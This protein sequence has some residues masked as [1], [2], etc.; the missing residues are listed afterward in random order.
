MKYIT[1]L[2]CLFLITNVSFAQ[3]IFFYDD[4]FTRDLLEHGGIKY[5]YQCGKGKI[6]KI[7]YSL[8]NSGYK[9]HDVVILHFDKEGNLIKRKA[10]TIYHNKKEKKQIP[11]IKNLCFPKDLNYQY[12]YQYNQDKQVSQIDSPW[13]MDINE[14]FHRRK[15]RIVYDKNGNVLQKIQ[16]YEDEA[17]NSV[18][19][20]QSYSYK[21]RSDNRLDS[22]VWIRNMY[23]TRTH[24][25]DERKK[26][27]NIITFQL[28]TITLRSDVKYIYNSENKL[29]N[30]IV[31]HNYFSEKLDKETYE[32]LPIRKRDKGEYVLKSKNHMVSFDKEDNWVFMMSLNAFT[33]RI[34][35]RRIEYYK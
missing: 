34:M 26:R 29:Q 18:F 2:I 17:N 27:D 19:P 21:Y 11:N 30:I 15:L 24:T 7:T 31:Y 33:N 1:L 23:K 3:D 28:D 10:N 5:A 32:V 8:R 12:P 22:A 14:S 20:D 4:F 25:K 9:S 35:D 6:K 13:S 16:I